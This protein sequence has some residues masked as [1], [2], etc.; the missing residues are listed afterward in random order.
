MLTTITFSLQ[1]ICFTSPVSQVWT[2]FL[3]GQ[4]QLE[5][6]LLRGD[7]QKGLLDS[8]EEIQT[9]SRDLMTEASKSHIHEFHM[10]KFS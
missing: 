4:P 9:K 8:L 7:Y 1:S 3:A 5:E 10:C 2:D 6:L